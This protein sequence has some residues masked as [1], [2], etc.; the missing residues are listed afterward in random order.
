MDSPPLKSLLSGSIRPLALLIG[1][2]F[3]QE[4]W[5]GFSYQSL[6]EKAKQQGLTQ[7]YIDLFNFLET[8][9]FEEMLR[10]L[11][12]STLVGENLNFKDC[13]LRKLKETK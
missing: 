5:K 4:I 7:E 6:F 3:S 9:N 8:Q 10:A 11:E 12:F 1:N 2:G 13:E